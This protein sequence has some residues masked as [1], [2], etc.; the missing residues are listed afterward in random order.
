[1]RSR[2]VRH[3]RGPVMN[4]YAN[5]LQ[6]LIATLLFGVSVSSAW[7]EQSAGTIKSV[8]GNVTVI[9]VSS[10]AVSASVGQQV[11]AGDK[12]VTGADAYVGLMLRDDTRL[13]LGPK[14]E[15]LV[16]SFHFTPHSYAGEVT[17]NFLRGTAM[18]VTGLIGK[19][20]PDRVNLSTP[21]TTIG[22]RGT[23][24]IVEVGQQ[25]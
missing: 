21:T 2:E 25:D 5:R 10:P 19:H 9:R 20:S 17:L 22:I 14:S 12:L 3:R 23:E 18:F 1:M 16:K 15:L 4:G 11:M 24:F 13:S 8:T 6:V 7:A